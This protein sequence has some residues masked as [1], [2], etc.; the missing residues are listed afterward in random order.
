MDNQSVPV[1]R[2][3]PSVWSDSSARAVLQL[4]VDSVAQ[5]T[6]FSTAAL[7][8]ILDDLL[9]TVAYTGPDEFRDLVFEHADPVSALD[10]VLERG[11]DW[12]RFRFV[13][14]DRYDDAADLDG[15]WFVLPDEGDP[16][17]ED[18][19][20]PHDILVA[21]LRD[22]EGALVGA[23]SLDG[24]LSG[25]RPDVAL[26][27][28]LERYAAQTERA[29][30]TAFEREELVQQVAHAEAARRMIRA[31]SIPVHASLD[32]VL[33]STHQ[34]LIEG[35]GAVG[36]WIEILE[37]DGGTRGYA[38]T[39]AGDL[40]VLPEWLHEVASELAP[41]LWREQR[42]A[43]L[44]A[45]G[46]AGAEGYDIA[47]RHLEAGRQL[48][49]ELGVALVIG[50]PL[51]AGEECLGFLVL[52][53]QDSRPHWSPVE[54]AS[55]LEIGHD[56]GAALMTVR[57]L[58]SE[59]A[60]VR[61]LKRLE[62]YRS[63]L[64]ATLSHELRTPLAVILGNLE[65]LGELDLD[66]G[67]ARH[68]RAMSRGAGRM[69]KVVDDLL[70]LAQVGDPRHPLVRIPVDLGRTAAD[71]LGLI[72]ST[73]EAKGVRIRRQG[74]EAVPAAL[75]VDGDPVELDR[76]LS[77]L[78]S[79]AVKYTP[80]GGVVTIDLQRDGEAVVVRVVDDGL[81]IS[82]EDQAGLFRA[83]FRTTNPAALREQGTGLG[84]AI[85]ATVVE[86]HAGT[87]RVTS[88]LGSG[89]TF[90]VRLPAAG[91]PGLPETR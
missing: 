36:T 49:A 5:M 53:R 91:A 22:D 60:L 15:Y 39:K 32:A 89:T 24:P 33:I 84:L 71:V 35:F 56:L 51:G 85:V 26:R 29:V 80:A 17:L 54:T 78:V 58:E 86:R 46:V 81:G 42:V 64:I 37:P 72:G 28:L 1:G 83:F 27:D 20:D 6:G 88:T 68:H 90:T 12:G 16:T 79:N 21:L 62:D 57:A 66:D 13:P 23:L 65:L 34:P 2:I 44:D 7:S 74:G 41:R 69:N 61:E 18:G 76:M 73:A 8:V 43:V 4:M 70:L 63:Q 14:A 45:D 50:I 47:G 87:V 82:E 55:A 52:P 48:L 40:V 3:D 25:R 38:R 31:A 67:A 59:R 11:D 9:V 75:V 19:W 77:N 30:L 10:L